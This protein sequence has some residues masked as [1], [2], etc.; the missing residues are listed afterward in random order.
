MRSHSDTSGHGGAQSSQDPAFKIPSHPARGHVPPNLGMTGWSRRS[1]RQG[2]RTPPTPTT[3]PVKK[4]FRVEL[5]VEAVKDL[6]RTSEERQKLRYVDV[7]AARPW[8]PHRTTI[9]E[10]FLFVE[11]R[12]GVS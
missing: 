3:V 4:K 8:D 7:E 6:G 1:S 2:D 10:S 11:R 5:L 12:C 9:S